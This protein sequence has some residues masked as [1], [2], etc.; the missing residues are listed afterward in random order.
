VLVRPS[1]RL[2][3]LRTWLAAS[4]CI[5]MASGSQLLARRLC[6]LGPD[7]RRPLVGFRAIQAVGAAMLQAT[8]WHHHD[9][10]PAERLGGP[11]H[12][13]AAQAVGLALGPSVGGFLLIA[14][15]AA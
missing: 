2:D 3:A 6:G 14:G 1:L 10:V 15:L 7:A 9:C 12:P 5:C 4:F 11:R 13:G 8:A